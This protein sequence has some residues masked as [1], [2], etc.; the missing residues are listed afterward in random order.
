MRVR[1]YDPEWGGCFH[2]E[3]Y[4]LLYTGILQRCIVV[5]DGLLRLYYQ[6]LPEEGHY[7]NQVGFVDPDFPA[8]WIRLRNGDLPRRCPFPRHRPEDPGGAAFHG[9][10]WVWEDQETLLRLLRG[11]AVPLGET[12]Y[13]PVSSRLPGWSYVTTEEEAEALLAAAH[14]FHDTVLVSLHYVS[15][16]RREER[17]ML[18]SDRVRQVTMLFHCDW[19]PPVQLVFEGVKA[20]NL[21]PVGTYGCS[22]LIQATCRVRNAMVFFCE[23]WCEEGEEGA[24]PDTAIWS[25]S[26]RWRF[27]TD[28][29]YENP[30]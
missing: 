12:A 6:T 8:E 18:V 2:S 9:Y 23:G 25:Y 21:R 7:R 24:F 27:L 26:L 1:V 10:P 17:G 14:D 30:S 3:L 15:G 19:T 5:R 16:S 20:L 28:S 13:P 29:E 4:G 11:E 22:A